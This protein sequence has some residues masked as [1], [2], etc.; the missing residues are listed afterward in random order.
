M[1]VWIAIGKSIS[2]SG[3]ACR[4]PYIH[5]QVDWHVDIHTFI[6]KSISI[7]PSSCRYACTPRWIGKSIC[8]YPSRCTYAC[9]SCV[10]L[11]PHLMFIYQCVRRLCRAVTLALTRIVNMA[12]M[13]I[14]EEYTYV[15]EHVMDSRGVYVCIPMYTS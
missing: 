13:W 8:M 10:L 9:P 1:N 4:Y 12:R 7:Y 5:W 15:Y 14:E 2:M 11:M 3:L 6:G